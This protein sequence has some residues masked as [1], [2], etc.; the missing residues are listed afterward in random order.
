MPA[1]NAG[2]A[3]EGRAP[4]V[5]NCLAIRQAARL[6][7]QIYDTE[8]A[9][10]GLRI[11]QYSL[12]AALNRLGPSSV[13]ELADDQV[14]DRSTLGHNLRPLEAAKLVV[15]A[16]DKSDRRAK[17]LTLSA[18]GRRKLEEARPL[19]LGAQARFEGQYGEAESKDLR[20]TLRQVVDRTAALV[21]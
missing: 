12:L 7:T 21:S 3:D 15:L 4:A 10:A 20:A 11:T 13:Q 18:K 16:V 6:I 8:L 1:M 2:E 9:P 19:W 14:L 17:R 5:C